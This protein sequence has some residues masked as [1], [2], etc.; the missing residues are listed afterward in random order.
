[1]KPEQKSIFNTFRM[2]G[3][4]YTLNITPPLKMLFL[5]LSSNLLFYILFFPSNTVEIETYP[6][7][8]IEV[9]V[10]AK[11]LTPFQI[12]KKITLYHSIT[13]KNVLAQLTSPPDEE[14]L[15]TVATDSESA[16]ALLIHSD[17]KIIPPIDLQITQ[18]NRGE[19]REIRY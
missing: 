11:L 4:S 16:K 1:M 7:D 10:Q 6:K 13:N 18:T 8:F 5:I 2:N 15:T 17:W 3:K 12:G 9:K 19:S 14:G